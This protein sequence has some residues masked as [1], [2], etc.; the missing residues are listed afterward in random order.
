M[1]LLSRLKG[2]AMQ[3]IDFW[4]VVESLMTINPIILLYL[5]RFKVAQ[6]QFSVPMGHWEKT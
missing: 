1:R 4:Q 2:L 6:I 5:S 3:L